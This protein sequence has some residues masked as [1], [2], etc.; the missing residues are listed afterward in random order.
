[1]ISSK[2]IKHV[3][4]TYYSEEAGTP[5]ES[6]LQSQFNIEGDGRTCA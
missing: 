6:S 1:M 3:A 2:G 5:E 4:E